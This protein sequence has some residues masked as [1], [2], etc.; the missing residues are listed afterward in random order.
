LLSR[1]RHHH[2]LLGPWFGNNNFV[3]SFIYL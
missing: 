3:K 2:K 1:W